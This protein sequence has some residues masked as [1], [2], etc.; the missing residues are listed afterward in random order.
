MPE[1]KLIDIA[2]ARKLIAA[3]SPGPWRQCQASDARCG[4]GL[5]WS[6]PID[7]PIAQTTDGD[8]CDKGSGRPEDA[9]FIAY[10][11][12]ALPAALDRIEALETR[13]QELLTFI[14]AQS[15]LTPFPD[16]AGQAAVLLAEVG[17]LRATIAERDRR[18]EDL[19]GAAYNWD[20]QR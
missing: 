11:R 16:E 19:M 7:Q 5:I 17:T 12:D 4:C 2:E 13:Q 10:A 1:A 15:Q 9:A 8:P 20:G 18:I 6:L 3:A 14:R